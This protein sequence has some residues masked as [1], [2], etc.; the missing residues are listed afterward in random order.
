MRFSTSLSVVA[1]ATLVT[2]CS[3]AGI[4]TTPGG[5]LANASSRYGIVSLVPANL[6]SPVGEQRLK[7]GFVYRDAKSASYLYGSE[8]ESSG[9]GEGQINAYKNPDPKNSKPIC[10]IPGYAVNGWGVDNAGDLILPSGTS[11]SSE[12]TVN[13]YQGPKPCGKELGSIT[14]STGQAA[15]ATSFNAVKDKIYVGEIASASAGTGE[16]VICTLKSKACGTPITNSAITGHGAGV[17]IDSKGD[18]W[19]S[20]ATSTNAGFLMVYWK[21]CKGAG[22]VATGTKNGGFGGLFFDTKGNLVSIDVSGTTSYTY[23]GCTPKCTLV[24]SLTM[25]GQS[26]F[27]NLN[28]A[29]TELAVGDIQNSQIDVYKYTPTKLTYMYSFNNGLNG[30]GFIIG[31]GFNPTNK[32]L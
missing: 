14:D 21:G 15:S 24:G 13:V 6:Q 18:C 19:M 12:P 4:T 2:A 23:K 8:F 17:A 30:T 1:L 20:A 22:V 5:A 27:G 9:S 26:I 31:G 32:Q 11:I 29:G 10:D 16:I 7:L 25:K 28:A 3:G